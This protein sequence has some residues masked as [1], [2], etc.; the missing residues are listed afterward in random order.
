MFAKILRVVRGLLGGVLMTIGIV[1]VALI[2]WLSSGSGASSKPGP[3]VQVDA[4]LTRAVAEDD[5]GAACPCAAGQMCQGPRG[6]RYCIKPDGSKK[7][8]AK[9]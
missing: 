9:K 7:Y 1:V 4:P 2:W 5:A 6:G 8:E 3:A